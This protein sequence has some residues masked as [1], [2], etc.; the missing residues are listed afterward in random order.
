MTYTLHFSS[1]A[2]KTIKKWAKSAPVLYKRLAKLLHEL[3]DHPKTGLG[4][5]EPLV[6]GNAIVYSRCIDAHHRIIYEV[7]DEDV[8]ILIVSVE[9]HYKDK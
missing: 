7:Y 5:P 9:G 6:G 1:N 3:I 2:D 8:V 4:H